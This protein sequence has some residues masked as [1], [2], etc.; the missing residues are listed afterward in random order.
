MKSQLFL[1]LNSLHL[2][3]CLMSITVESTA[4]I[5]CR[6]AHFFIISVNN[7]CDLLCIFLFVCL[8]LL[9]LYVSFLTLFHDSHLFL[10]NHPLSSTKT[11]SLNN[12]SFFFPC[13]RTLY[14]IWMIFMLHKM[15]RCHFFNIKSVV[16]ESWDKA[17]STPC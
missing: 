3:K 15:V 2:P 17:I 8:S 13:E 10:R 12:I 9:L 14:P 1:V 5:S 6:M 4:F 7:F 16:N 11:D